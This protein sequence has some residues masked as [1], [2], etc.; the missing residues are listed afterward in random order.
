MNLGIDVRKRVIGR[1]QGVYLGVS[2]AAGQ[3]SAVAGVSW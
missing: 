3:A 2:V 1:V